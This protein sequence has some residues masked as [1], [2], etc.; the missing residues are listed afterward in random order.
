[1]TRKQKKMLRKIV[2]ASIIFFIACIFSFLLPDFPFKPWISLAIFLV[3]YL[4]AGEDVVKKAFF[5]G[6]TRLYC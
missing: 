6:E 5:K 2:I 1:M 4:K 3:A